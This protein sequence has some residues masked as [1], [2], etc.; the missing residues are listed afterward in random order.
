[1]SIQPAE[2]AEAWLTSFA[3]ACKEATESKSTDQVVSH[4]LPHGWWRD[5]ICLTW[6]FRTAEGHEKI[7]SFIGANAALAKAGFTNLK[8]DTTSALGGPVMKQIPVPGMDKPLDAIEFS[9]RFEL[10]HPA[11]VGRALAT[12]AQDH[13]PN[14]EWKAFLLLTSLEHLKGH[15]PNLTPPTGHYEG[16]TRTWDD[17]HAEELAAVEK[18]HTVLVVGGGHAESSLL[19]DCATWE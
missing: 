13:G 14:K 7:A 11:G 5:R 10:A 6:D 9:F 16:H 19:F 17:V 3:D 15:E 2:I 4:F 8:I 12:L 1:M 18:D